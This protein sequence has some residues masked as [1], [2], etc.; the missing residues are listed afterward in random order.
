M[1]EIYESS[2]LASPAI[3][4]WQAIRD[5]NALPQWHEAIA[6][7]RIEG[8][9]PADKIG[10]VRAFTLKDGGFLREKLLALS[11]YDLSYSYSVLESPM[12]IEN[13]VATLSLIPVTDGDRCFIEWKA[14]FDCPPQHTEELLDAI[15]RGVFRLGFESL[16]KRFG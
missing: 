11:D 9:V 6:E 14:E 13:Y 5:F 4:V 8:N 7:S 10:C 16:K 3:R 2:I 12:P 15:G 1:A